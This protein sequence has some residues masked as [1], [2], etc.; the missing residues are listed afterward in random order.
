MNYV[1]NNRSLNQC[2]LTLVESISLVVNFSASHVWHECFNFLS[3]HWL[4]EGVNSQKI[5][6]S[7]KSGGCGGYPLSPHNEMTCPGNIAVINASD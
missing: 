4:S 6:D 1:L 2:V 5:T 3:Y 7:V